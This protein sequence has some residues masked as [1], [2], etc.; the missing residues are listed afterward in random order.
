MGTGK[1][2]G[3]SYSRCLFTSPDPAEVTANK[4][5]LSTQRQPFDKGPS[6]ST[7]TVHDTMPIPDYASP[8]PFAPADAPMVADLLL[9]RGKYFLASKVDKTLTPEEGKVPFSLNYVG[10]VRDRS[11]DS[12][13]LLVDIYGQAEEFEG[14]ETQIMGSRVMRLEELAQA[15]FFP[16]FKSLQEQTVDS[17]CFFESLNIS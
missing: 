5:L 6:W 2:A 17:A 3:E 4:L 10:V 7:P 11:P 13:F 1:N 9:S 16:S 12:R 14:P 15:T 8:T